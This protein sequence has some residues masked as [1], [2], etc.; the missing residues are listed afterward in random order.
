MVRAPECLFTPDLIGS[1]ARGIPHMLVDSCMSADLDLR[2]DL[3]SNIVL[4]GGS[5]MY[6]GFGDRLLNEVK[7]LGPKDTKIKIY[8]PQGRK[9][10]TWIGGSILGSLGTFKQMWVTSQQ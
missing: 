8:A 4:S 5:T 1:E 7:S 9:H 6:R 10:S 3:F 2:A